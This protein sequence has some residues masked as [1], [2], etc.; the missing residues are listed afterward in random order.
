MPIRCHHDQKRQNGARRYS[1]KL[2]VNGL[3]SRFFPA[4][5]PS[6]LCRLQFILSTPVTAGQIELNALEGDRSSKPV[7]IGLTRVWRIHDSAKTT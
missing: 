5:V 7:H 1:A 6:L 3:I 4:L 2:P